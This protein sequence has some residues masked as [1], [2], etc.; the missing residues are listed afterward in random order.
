MIVTA[1]PHAS[2]PDIK[3]IT[4]DAEGRSLLL[5]LRN[6]VDAI[7]RSCRLHV[8]GPTG[9]DV[10]RIHVKRQDKMLLGRPTVGC[11]HCVQKERP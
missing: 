8:H 3:N 5:D 4:Y 11:G 9:I 7:V 10:A 1:I 2:V 6:E